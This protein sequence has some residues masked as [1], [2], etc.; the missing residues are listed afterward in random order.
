MDAELSDIDKGFIAALIG[1]IPLSEIAEKLELTKAAVKRYAVTLGC[2]ETKADHLR[3][4][5]RSGVQKKDA[6]LIS[7]VRPSEYRRIFGISPEPK[8]KCGDVFGLWTVISEAGK[9]KWRVKKYLCECKCGSRKEL[10]H[11][12]LS[13]MKSCSCGCESRK[14]S[15]IDITQRNPAYKTKRKHGNVGSDRG[16]FSRVLKAYKYKQEQGCSVRDACTNAG[17]SIA[18]WYKYINEIHRGGE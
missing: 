13:G 9:T 12:V 1:S 2:Y 7:G 15:K 16:G 3:A 14:Q 5:H 11:D 17:A 10:R 18:T 8:I 4:L 6:I